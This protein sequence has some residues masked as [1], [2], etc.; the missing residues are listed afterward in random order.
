MNS[1]SD[2]VKFSFEDGKKIYETFSLWEDAGFIPPKNYLY[3]VELLHLS[4][5]NG[6]EILKRDL[7]VEFSENITKSVL[8]YNDS[9]FISD[10][11]KMYRFA[12]EMKIETENNSD[13]YIAVMITAGI[14]AEYMSCCEFHDLL[15]DVR[16]SDF[17]QN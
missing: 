2:L 6:D 14:I 15:K 10:P 11:D 3:A 1:E 13:T 17:S 16:T 12:E 8:Q 5:L 9:F 7:L 4:F